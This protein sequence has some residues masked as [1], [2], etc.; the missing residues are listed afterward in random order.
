[1]KALVASV[2]FMAL[3]SGCS[4]T[5]Y[6]LEARSTARPSLP[7]DCPV[8]VLHIPPAA[9]EEL[10]VLSR[11][12]DG[13]LTEEAFLQHVRPQVCGV[14]GNAVLVRLEGPGIYAGGV[15][16]YINDVQ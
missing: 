3:G 5:M 14:G 7:A 15:I 16:L 2:A 4:A 10:G 8:R 1:M 6:R 11:I 12:V 13:A 9:H